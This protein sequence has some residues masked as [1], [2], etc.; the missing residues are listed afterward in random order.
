L[1]AK[2]TVDGEH[3]IACGLCHERAPENLDMD[4]DAMQARVT[5]QPTSARQAAACQEAA[6]YCP[7]GG[8][9]PVDHEDR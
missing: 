9:R 3:C 1:P 2:Y 4:E 6:E 8:L 5:R 7:T